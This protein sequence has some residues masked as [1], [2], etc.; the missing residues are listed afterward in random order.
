MG[1]PGSSGRRARPDLRPVHSPDR[2]ARPDRSGSNRSARPSGRWAGGGRRRLSPR[3]GAGRRPRR[4]RTAVA[5]S[6]P[7]R[8]RPG[9]RRNGTDDR[10]LA[11]TAQACR[12]HC[13]CPR[14]CSARQPSD[15]RCDQSVS[16]RDR[17]HPDNSGM[18]RLGPGHREGRRSR[19]TPWSASP[20]RG[21]PAWREIE[22]VVCLASA[23]EWPGGK[24]KPLAVAW[25]SDEGRSP[26]CR[27]TA[28]AG[29]RLRRSDR[30]EAARK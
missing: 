3:A 24:A 21:R 17:I 5:G 6:D 19:R 11:E 10:K 29:G 18:D 15:P 26:R 20:G 13:E 27:G 12:A 14:A 16:R 4:T 30:R 28:C 9:P 25:F 8:C 2:T 1:R 7:S 22:A 23:G